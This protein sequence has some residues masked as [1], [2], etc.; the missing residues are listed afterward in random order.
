MKKIP[1][2]IAVTVISAGVFTLCLKAPDNPAENKLII[3]EYGLEPY[4]N[5]R[6]WD[7][8]QS[9]CK[10]VRIPQKFTGRFKEFADEM[11][12]SGFNL[13]SHKGEEVLFYT[14]SV[15]NYGRDGVIACMLL[16]HENELIASALIE[17]KPDGFIKSA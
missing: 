6:G 14:F 2:L 5:I 9:D 13:E 16:T 3:D 15:N 11:Q 17:Q 12:K 10:T 4:L 1:I 7:V 8:T